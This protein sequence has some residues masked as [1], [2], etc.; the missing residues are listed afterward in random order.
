ME[1]LQS[2]KGGSKLCYEGFIYTR[3]ALRKTKQWWKCTL[4]SSRECRGSL[5]TDLQYDNPS[6]GQPHNHA[7]DEASINCTNLRN[8]M[9]KKARSSHNA[10]NQSPYP[11]VQ[12]QSNPWS[13]SRT[14]V[15]DLSDAT[16]LNFQLPNQCIHIVTFCLPTYHTWIWV[17]TYCDFLSYLHTCLWLCPRSFVTF[18]PVT[19]CQFTMYNTINGLFKY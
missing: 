12:M 10:P 3:H 6:P 19:F 17:Y 8:N 5:S 9:K 4:K 7:P 16:D 1:I 11:I 2:N 13:M 14:T 15:R 18:C